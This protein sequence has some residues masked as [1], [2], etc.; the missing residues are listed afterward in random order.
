MR[1]IVQWRLLIKDVSVGT[2]E[3]EWIVT[4]SDYYPITGLSTHCITNKSV[5]LCFSLEKAETAQEN[6]KKRGVSSMQNV[7]QKLNKF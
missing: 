6:L 7:L 1:E 4:H 2:D 3:I 5:L